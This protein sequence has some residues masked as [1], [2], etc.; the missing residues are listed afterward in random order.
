MREVVAFIEAKVL[1]TLPG[2]LPACDM[3][4]QRP[5]SITF[6]I[7]NCRPGCPLAGSVSDP[8]KSAQLQ[9]S[10]SA[11]KATAQFRGHVATAPAPPEASGHSL[12]ELHLCALRSTA[13]YPKA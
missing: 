5:D 9:G 8:L 2:D 1:N 6:S 11:D 3:C 13:S 7:V 4:G 10:S 12:A